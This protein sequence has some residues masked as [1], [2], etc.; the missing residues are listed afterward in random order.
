MFALVHTAS[1]THLE[2]LA[3]DMQKKVIHMC[4]GPTT[5][6]TDTPRTG[7]LILIFLPIGM[8]VLIGWHVDSDRN[9]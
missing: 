7:K 9:T 6:E 5:G 1:A 8:L 4:L 2:G 3:I